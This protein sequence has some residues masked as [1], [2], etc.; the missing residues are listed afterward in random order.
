VLVFTTPCREALVS[1][2][3]LLRGYEVLATYFLYS[4]LA[5]RTVW[6]HNVVCLSV[7]LY[8]VALRVVVKD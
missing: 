6:R 2:Y 8:I 7:T 5:D 3:C 1:V 4:L